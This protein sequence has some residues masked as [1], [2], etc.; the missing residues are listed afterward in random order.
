VIK[1]FQH[2]QIYAKKG[3]LSRNRSF[4]SW[5]QK[6]N[7]K[8]GEQ[9]IENLESRKLLSAA[10]NGT[11]LTVTGS[12]YNDK[13]TIVGD[14]NY[15]TVNELNATSS[16]AGVTSIVVLG[17]KGNDYI[18]NLTQIPSSLFGGSGN[19]YL[20][21]GGGSDYLWGESGNDVIS[22]FVPADPMSQN[23]LYGGTGNDSLWG[24]FGALDALFG[25]T[26]NDIIYDI[27]GGS[28]VVNADAGKDITITR[29]TDLVNSDPKDAAAV[30]F[31]VST[32]TVALV[33]G[34]V[35]LNGTANPDKFQ[36]SVNKTN[37]NVA[38]TLGSTITNYTFSKK[39]VKFIAGIGGDGDDQFINDTAI[40]SVFYG[41]GGNDTLVGG[42]GID[43]LKGGAGSDNLNGRKGN[44]DMSGDA[45]ADIIF[46]TDG[47]DIFRADATDTMGGWTG[48][49]D[50]IVLN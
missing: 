31:G 8:P 11:I 44:D 41:T 25:G 28:N 24:G 6:Y 32:D 33:K 29:A 37:I 17:D 14:S 20:Q 4:N 7:H 49:S 39:A 1:E 5:K 16:F 48:G 36:I 42:F 23:K 9:M 15:L 47:T 22:D 13:I 43:I 3:K 19:D 18:A 2:K 34:V 50:L 12:K 27:V 21:G 46:D 38:Y 10:L 26:G 30:S 35:Y 45:G 40:G